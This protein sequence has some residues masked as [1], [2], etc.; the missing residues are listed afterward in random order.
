[1]AACDLFDTAHSAANAPTYTYFEFF[2]GGRRLSCGCTP[3]QYLPD[4]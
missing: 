2:V 4:A 1:M 3:G